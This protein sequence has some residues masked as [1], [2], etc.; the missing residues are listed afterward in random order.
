MHSKGQG[1]ADDVTV[2]RSRVQAQRVVPGSINHHQPAQIQPPSKANIL[3]T[4][5]QANPTKKQRVVASSFYPGRGVNS[6]KLSSLNHRNSGFHTPQVDDEGSETEED[7]SD[8]EPS[9]ELALKFPNKFSKSLGVKRPSWSSSGGNSASQS[10]STSTGDF[11]LSTV[12]GQA[13]SSPLSMVQPAPVAAVVSTAQLSAL[14]IDLLNEVAPAVA[15]L[16]WPVHTELVFASGSDRLRLMNQCP[17]V[18]LIRDCLL[19]AAD[20]LQPGSANILEQLT[21]DLDYLSKMTPRLRARISLIRSEVKECCMIITAGVFLMFGSPLDVINYIG[22][23]L[24][25]YTYTFPKAKLS[26]APNGLVMRLQPYQ[27]DHIITAIQVLYFAGGA[28]SFAK[29]FQYLFPTYETQKGEVCE[30]PIHMVALV[31][32]V[33]YATIREWS[34]G[35]QVIAEFSANAYLDVYNSHVNMLKHIQERHE[36]GFHLKMANIYTQANETPVSESNSV[37]PIAELNL[38]SI[39]G[40]QRVSI[41]TTLS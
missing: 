41:Y 36:G 34:T 28:K 40:Y 5:T 3:S 26:N 9:L 30:V 15:Q 21:H 24:S 10:S 29:Q 37:V 6:C 16:T 22:K 1:R 23:Q 2:L 11:S 38:D 4:S 27:N 33:L 25:Q 35:E 7:P 14:T 12:P 32:T 13:A 39:N 18:R 31:A 8:E 20:Q 17:M 19:N